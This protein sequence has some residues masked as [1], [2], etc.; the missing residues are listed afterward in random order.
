MNQLDR[1]TVFDF[2]TTGVDHK[3]CTPVEIGAVRFQSGQRF[4]TLINPGVPIPPEVSA[5][6]HIIDGDVASA[7]SWDKVK[8]AFY[9]FVSADQDALPILVAH[10]AQFEKDFLGEFPPVLWICTYK[11]ALRIWPDAPGHKNEVLR[12]W[13]KLGTN[14][15]RSAGQAPHSAL[16]DAEVTALLLREMLNHAT[17]D[18]LVEWTELPAKLPKM[19]MGKHFG[20][21]W[22]TVPGPYLQWCINQADMRED[23]KFCA[24]EELKRRKSR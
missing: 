14:R 6:H 16:H 24:S 10:N 17:I 4:N 15:G 13:L 9:D 7:D 19:P 5:V 20:Q 11:C 8:P 1:C 22:D 2:E 21:T 12:Y 23:V 18:Q 3:T